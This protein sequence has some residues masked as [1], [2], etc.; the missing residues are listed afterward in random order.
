MSTGDRSPLSSSYGP[1]MP[2]GGF[3]RRSCAVLSLRP[4]RARNGRNNAAPLPHRRSTPP[5]SLLKMR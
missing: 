4:W 3:E 5:P 2:L 1:M